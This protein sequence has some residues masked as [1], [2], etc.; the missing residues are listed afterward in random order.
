MP[1]IDFHKLN[2][3]NG[4]VIHENRNPVKGTN[5]NKMG[6]SRKWNISKPWHI[7][8]KSEVQ[9]SL[10]CYSVQRRRRTTSASRLAWGLLMHVVVD[11]GVVFKQLVTN[12]LLTTT[13]FPTAKFPVSNLYPAPPHNN[14][15]H[16]LTS[17]CWAHSTTRRHTHIFM[18]RNELLFRTITTNYVCL[19]ASSPQ[20]PSGPPSWL[21][22]K[23]PP[24]PRTMATPASR[25]PKNR[26]WV[27]NRF[28]IE[29]P[30][31]QCTHN[32]S[33][34]HPH[35]EWRPLALLMMT[36]I[37]MQSIYRTAMPLV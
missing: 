5:R 1:R 7:V 28:L 8:G 18:K 34:F 14:Q 9:S 32:Q 35:A 6:K 36:V 22:L 17:D 37:N 3:V 16:W 21:F 2:R 19:S 29:K 33:V 30:L 31:C 24:R 15:L 23:V 25:K 26:I 12:S 11:D 27:M 4:N 13:T 10:Y 20:K